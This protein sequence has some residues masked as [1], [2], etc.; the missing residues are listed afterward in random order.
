MSSTEENSKM[1]T[2]EENSK[3]TTTQK[4]NIY[5]NFPRRKK[6]KTSNDIND[7][8]DTIR[9]LCGGG[10]SCIVDRRWVGDWIH[11]DIVF[12]SNNIPLRDN[13]MQNYTN[14]QIQALNLQM[15]TN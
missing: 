14:E 15:N 4:H 3:I 9:C 8:P 13:C 5:K 11:E 7:M 12:N 10:Q 2:T 6:N 1:T